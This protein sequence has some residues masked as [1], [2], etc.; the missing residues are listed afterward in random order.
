MPAPLEAIFFDVDDTLFSTTEF[1]AAARRNAV[2]AM[3]Q[4]GLDIEEDECLR[5]LEE[6]IQEFSS[7]YEHHFDK[8]LL[9]LPR[10]RLRGVSPLVLVAAGMTGYHDTKFHGLSPY[11]DAIEVL[12]ILGERGLK[13][14]IISAGI[15]IKQAEKVV[16]LGLNALVSSQAIFI[17]DSIGIAKSN[18]KL[19]LRACAH[20]H[21]APERTMYVGDNPAVDVDV[22]HEAGMITVHSRRSGKHLND[23]NQHDPDHIIHNFWDLLEIIDNQY[24]LVTA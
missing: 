2:R 19:Y 4:A 6:V 18:P 14:G 10:E 7:N 12:K 21:V 15:G 8:L 5:E 22:P 1:A 20:F 16:R 3:I 13:L 24:E 17:T 23:E 11:E 9:R